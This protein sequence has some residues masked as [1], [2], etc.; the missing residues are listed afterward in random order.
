M[1]VSSLGWLG[2]RTP[3]AAA[4]TAFY[5][6]VLGLEVILEKPG[7]TWFRLGDGAEVHVYGQDDSDHDF[8]GSSPVPGFWVDSFEAARAALE[9]AGIEFIYPEP[10][11][12]AG[13]AWQHFRG[14]DG[15]VYE[16]IGP[17]DLGSATPGACSQLSSSKRERSPAR[18]P[19][20]TASRQP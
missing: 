14:P 1:A 16:I 2:V 19:S 10:Q 17:D 5:R 12:A 3:N 11:R 7:A 6:D 13:R 18:R 15:N 4:M 20:L 9:T 8:F